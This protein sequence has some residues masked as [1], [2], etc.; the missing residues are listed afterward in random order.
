ME[1]TE[2]KSRIATL[3]DE[4]V[5]LAEDVQSSLNASNIDSSMETNAQVLTMIL[6]QGVLT[7]I[8]SGLQN[9]DKVLN[10][11]DAHERT[12]G[13]GNVTGLSF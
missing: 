4:V 1:L 3:T 7:T 8:I 12:R 10:I 13:T 5:K 11:A 9:A 6:M 2:L